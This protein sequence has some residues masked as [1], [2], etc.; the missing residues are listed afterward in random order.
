[1]ERKDEMGGSVMRDTR[2]ARTVV[3]WS[4]AALALWALAVPSATAAGTLTKE[5]VKNIATKVVNSK[6]HG[7]K[8]W[9]FFHQTETSTS[10][11]VIGK[12]GI[13]T[14]KGTCDGAGVPTL[15]ASWTKRVDH[16]TLDGAGGLF[17]NSQVD[18]GTTINIGS[19]TFGS[20]GHA[21]A[22]TYATP[23]VLT[24]VEYFLRDA[25]AL[26]QNKCFFSG[27]VTIK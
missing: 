1:M 17:G 23:H 15:R 14:L 4:M 3:T 7:I 25:P 9:R 20:V 24:S 13:I 6:I 12:F 26:G 16:M 2:W 8:M 5:Q 11:D 10:N 21:E 27:I 19:G 18:G 22:V